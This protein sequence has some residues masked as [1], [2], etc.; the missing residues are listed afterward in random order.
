MSADA[1]YFV[2]LRSELENCRVKNDATA[3]IL[4]CRLQGMASHF[5]GSGFVCW[6]LHLL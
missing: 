1:K 6:P 4:H 2:F 3:F 5:I